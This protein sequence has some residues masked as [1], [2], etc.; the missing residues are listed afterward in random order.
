MFHGREGEENALDAARWLHA[1]LGVPKVKW[2]P[3]SRTDRT[4]GFS[5]LVPGEWVQD[6]GKFKNKSLGEK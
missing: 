4:G 5:E 3:G 1:V 2:T 6:L